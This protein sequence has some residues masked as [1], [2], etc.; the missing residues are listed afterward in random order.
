MTLLQLAGAVAVAQSLLIAISLASK[1]TGLRTSNFLL[2]A[3]FV[4]FAL[5][6]AGFAALGSGFGRYER[7]N[8]PA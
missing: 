3:L 4:S 2:S 5:L 7:R 6:T 1:K 8:T